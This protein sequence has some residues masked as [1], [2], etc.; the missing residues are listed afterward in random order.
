LQATPKAR[1][2]LAHFF[3]EM[4][5]LR[6]VPGLSKDD[7]LYPFFNAT[8]A[9][10]MR[11]E[12]Q[13]LL[14]EIVWDKNVDFRSA[15]D[16]DYTFVNK[17]LATLYGLPNPP[18]SGWARVTLPAETGRGGVLGQASF[19]SLMAHTTTT[20]PTFRGKFVREHLL[21]QP[22]AAPPPNVDTNLPDPKPG[23]PPKTM[24]DKLRE[25]VSNPQCSG[26]HQ[27]MDP[28]GLGLENFDAVGR[29]RTTEN[30]AP[31]D[32]VSEF[33]TRGRFTGPKQLGQLLKG[34]ERMLKCLV[35]SV[36]RMGAGHVD[37][38]GE[39]PALKRLDAAFAADNYRLQGLLLEVVASDA[40]RYAALGEVRP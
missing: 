19:L 6:D 25:H 27:M 37:T 8:L 17:D 13:R 21:C 15:F 36:F 30:G 1:E 12:T 38:A 5:R 7:T 35:R 32:A 10:A 20:S 24:R 4:F 3:D 9:G 18:Q 29:Y 2:A 14:T 11:E 28:I 34:D 23:E 26:C 16:A 40:F 22:L 33:D 39:Q 31:V